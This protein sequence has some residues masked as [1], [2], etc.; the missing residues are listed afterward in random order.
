VAAT[1]IRNILRWSWIACNRFS[2]RAIARNAVWTGSV[3][4]N[5]ALP[6]RDAKAGHAAL[7]PLR[8]WSKLTILLADDVA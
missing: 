7:S 5:L 8:P 4:R 2:E 6:L 1:I 3:L